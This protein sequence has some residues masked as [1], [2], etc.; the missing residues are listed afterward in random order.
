MA[1]EQRQ[2]AYHKIAWLGTG[3]RLSLLHSI[4]T[5]LPRFKGKGNRLYP[6]SENQRISFLKNKNIL[7]FRYLEFHKILVI[8]TLHV[9]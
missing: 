8:L 1:K 9:T 4:V 2:A 6:F 7:L 3:T 5:A